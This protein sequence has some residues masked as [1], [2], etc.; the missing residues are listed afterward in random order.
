MLEQ[1]QKQHQDKQTDFSRKQGEKA[2]EEILNEANKQLQII[3]VK[4][5]NEAA[6]EER[7]KRDLAKK[8]AED[9]K[10]REQ[11]IDPTT[12]EDVGAWG[13]GTMMDAARK[14]REEDDARF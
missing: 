8:A 3:M 12:N 9:Q 14:K 6:A 1:R 7:R 5:M 10:K 11:G 4:R 13:R 2:K